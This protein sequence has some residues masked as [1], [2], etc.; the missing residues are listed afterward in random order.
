MCAVDLTDSK[1]E[2][3]YIYLYL[4]PLAFTYYIACKSIIDHA[5]SKLRLLPLYQF[6]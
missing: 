4:I 5:T 1:K 2:E 3:S 6:L